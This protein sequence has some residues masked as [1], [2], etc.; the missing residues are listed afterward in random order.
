[1]DRAILVENIQ[2][3]VA[4]IESPEIL[5]GLE[6]MIDDML[7]EVDE[8][9]A[10]VQ[11]SMTKAKKELD[12]GKGISHEQIMNEIRSKYPKIG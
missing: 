4:A 7:L 10:H 5:K 2:H 12:E 8:L 11:E 6:E 9:P 1:M 3:K